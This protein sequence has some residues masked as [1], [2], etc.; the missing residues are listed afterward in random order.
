MPSRDSRKVRGSAGAS[1]SQETPQPRVAFTA[2]SADLLL[3]RGGSLILTE[4]MDQNPA[5]QEFQRAWGVV[6]ESLRAAG[7]QDPRLRQALRA[8]AESLLRVV[9][10]AERVEALTVGPAGLGEKVAP[11][12]GTMPPAGPP[13]PAPPPPPPPPPPVPMTL[14][15]GDVT[16]PLEVGGAPAEAATGPATVPSLLRTPVGA[17]RVVHEAPEPSAEPEVDL[18]VVARRCRLKAQACRW[19]AERP[20]LLADDPATAAARHQDL[21]AQAKA[22]PDCYLWMLAPYGP[23]LPD[24]DTI[25]ALAGSYDA[26][27]DAAD[28]VAALE[29]A[30]AGESL[31][32]QG[33]QLL[34]EAQSAVRVGM[35]PGDRRFEDRDQRDAFLWLKQQTRGRG[36]YVQRHM[37][38][39]DGADPAGWFDRQERI[40]ALRQ[41]WDQRQQQERSRQSLLNKARYHAGHAVASDGSPSRDD[42]RKLFAATEE[43]VRM[44]V[45]PSDTELRELMLPLLDDIPPDAEAGPGV[46]QVLREIDRYLS[47]TDRE[48]APPRER[49]TGEEVRR[50]ADLLRG[51]RVILIGGANR[52]HAK[53]ALERDFELEELVWVITAAHESVSNFEPLVARPDTAL[54]ILAIR[55]SSHSFGE[56]QRICEAYGKPFVR[57]PAGYNPQQVARQILAQCSG[58]LGTE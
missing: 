38:L 56:V 1:P 55:W 40:A 27:A 7:R 44:G 6:I 29:S 57:L 13:Q 10:E 39:D 20:R 9:E 17:P 24:D 16:V 30:H 52:P 33:F 53:A 15:I 58:R 14:R 48:P 22:L 45:P 26:L 46:Q 36:I 35:G 21:I 49:R 19:A 23:T 37:R 32:E 50:V 18:R 41:S 28:L 34:A 4:R 47:T 31:V 8:V 43:L 11:A 42:W 3:G 54:V 12:P 5:D 2:G 51:K 25:R